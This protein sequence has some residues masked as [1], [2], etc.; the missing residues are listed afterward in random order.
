MM[1]IPHRHIGTLYELSIEERTE[2]IEVTS[3][4]T[5]YFEKILRNSSAN[6]GINLGDAGGGGVPKHLHIHRSYALTE[7][8]DQI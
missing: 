3:L 2:L 5:L 6:I 8:Y 4:C 1:A 7:S